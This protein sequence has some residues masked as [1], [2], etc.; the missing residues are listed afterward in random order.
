[1]VI[2]RP[3][4]AEPGGPPTDPEGKPGRRDHV[5]LPGEHGVQ[6]DED[7]PDPPPKTDS[8]EEEVRLR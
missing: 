7:P 2:A 3:L 1:V 8:R 5:A 4:E 6:P